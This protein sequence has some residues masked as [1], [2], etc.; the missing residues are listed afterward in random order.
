MAQN[1][2]RRLPASQP[3]A[4]LLAHLHPENRF[5]GP[6]WACFSPS[7]VG[8]FRSSE[9]NTEPL[10]QRFEAVRLTLACQV[11]AWKYST[12]WNGFP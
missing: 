12:Q 5:A 6:S 2:L 10:K 1:G 9:Q 11:I 3:Q 8:Q 4:R 7:L